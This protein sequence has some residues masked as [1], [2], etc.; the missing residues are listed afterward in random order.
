MQERSHGDRQQRLTIGDALSATR[1][2]HFRPYGV[3]SRGKMR[4]A[5]LGVALAMLAAFL[6]MVSPPLSAQAES[7]LPNGPMFQTQTFYAYA[8]DGETLDVDFSKF[9]NSGTG[10]DTTFA[11]TD[12]A[13]TVAY[14]CSVLA[15][16]P[17]GTECATTG[18]TG[19]AGVWTIQIAMTADENS[20]WSRFD[21]DITVRD[22]G[23]AQPGR[24]WTNKYIMLQ[25]GDLDLTYHL[26]NDSGYQYNV[27]LNGYN[28]I[29]SVIAANALGLTDAEC[30][31]LYQSGAG[32]S[33]CGP[34]YRIFF[35]EPDATLPATA[36]SAAGTLSVLPPVL[37]SDDL[38]VDD[39]TFAPGALNSANGTFTYSITDRF[40][41]GYELQID[42]DGNGSYSDAVDRVVE[43]G[44]DGSG[45]YSYDFD[46]LDGEGVAIADCT[47]IN[48]RIF[49]GKV[50]EVHVLQ[51]DV[52][53]RAGGIEI[54]RTNGSGAPDSTIYWDDTTLSDDRVTTTPQVDGTAGVDSTGG[55][56]GWDYAS[57]NGWG[58]A[59]NIDDWAYNPIN[60]GTG[61]ISIG[62][63]CL[64]IEK[65][66]NATAESRVGDTVT[67]TV[68]ATNT[69]DTDYTAEEP[70]VLTDDLTGVLDDATFNNDATSDRG[71]APS[72]TEPK[73]R[74]AGALPAGE[75]VTVSYTV[76]LTAGG[77][78]SVRNVA[79]DGDG[80]TPACDP[81][82]ADGTDPETGVACA[83][84]DNPLPKLTVTKTADRTDLPAVGEQVTYTVTVTNQGPG[85]YTADAPATA[86]DNFTDI[87]DDATF[88][89]GSVTASTG[90]TSYTDPIL[91]WE[92]A[93]GVGEMATVS[94]TFTYTGGGDNLLRNQ[95]C[96]PSDEAAQGAEPCA[97]VVVP[98]AA[99]EQSKSVDP[100][101]GTAVRAGQEVTYTLTFDNVGESAGA[102]D[103][104]DDLSDVLD[105]AE[106]SAGPTVTGDG[107]TATL[108]GEQIDI[109]GS[110]AAGDTVT[111]SYTV[112]VNAYADQANHQLGNVLADPDG[113][114]CVPG[115]EACATE[116]PIQHLIVEKTS[117]AQAD[118][119]TGDTVTYTVTVTNDGESDFTADAPASANDD[120]TAVLDDAQ[121]N[122]DATTDAGTV[123]YTEPTLSWSGPLAA[124]ESVSITYTVLVTNAGDHALRN[125]ASLPSELCD[126]ADAPC[127]AVV[128]T[129]LPHVVPTKISDPATGTDVVA[130]QVVTYTL[131]YTNDGQADGV[132]DSTDDLTDVLDDADITAEPVSSSANVTAVR[133]GATLRVTGSIAVGETVTVTYQITIKADGDRGNNRAENVLVPDVPEEFDC[134]SGECVPV[135][136]PPVVHLMPELDDWKTVD[137]AS[138]A[139]VAPGSTVTY[140]LNFANTGTATGVVNREDVLTGVID[141]ADLVSGPTS[142]D[143]ALT[144][145]DVTDGRFT[146]TGSLAAGQTVTVTYTVTVREDGQRGDDQLANFLVD[147]GQEPPA[148]CVV[149]DP[150]RPDCTVNYVSNVVAEKSSDP[151]SGSDVAQGE[152]ITYTLTFANTS[153]NPLAADS[154]VEYTDHMADVLD[155][156][157]LSSGPTASSDALS[158]TTEGTTIVITGALASGATATVSYTVTVKP[159]SEQGNHGLGNVV[160]ITGTDPICVSGS[161]LCTFHN[162]VKPSP[163]LASTGADVGAAGLFGL[164][165][166]F[167]GA[168]VYLI[169]RRRQAEA[170][171]ENIGTAGG[172]N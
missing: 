7:S 121:F 162:P 137:P 69:G 13:G 70:A 79:F 170:T 26:V 172:S 161:S 65:S 101:S 53:G 56:H 140:T 127:E 81:P 36:P 72:Y 9:G 138:G 149:T 75:S 47:L 132:V 23:T 51:N 49:F 120:L 128:E 157:T 10:L 27:N 171:A 77:D 11:I 154:A 3:L 39:L 15:A 109:A 169:A 63:R 164:L 144:A 115:P 141:D 151:E 57:P 20:N 35:D 37:S 153:S 139:T 147:P 112:I 148:E 104:F 14:N 134:T 71:D 111:V 160:A 18:L 131:G 45:S 43:L 61:E 122:D 94:Y 102:V 4:T 89:E 159:Y 12:A 108:N 54:I 32:N 142:S 129:L 76:D 17:A 90:E 21:W 5:A 58:D 74:W 64:S 91:S 42:T 80:D 59:R 50:G 155:D 29:G 145:S 106:L 85:V 118:V 46:G 167:A 28:G 88:D 87:L 66:S 146:V 117:D 86:S 105:D 55:V 123:S 116:N 107:L 16:A 82:T 41:G 119:N 100:E 96:I 114:A 73:I 30:T 158:V 67:Y 68:T 93:L 31:P 24:V 52:E 97:T 25:T 83:V 48:A 163:G 130:G 166:L 152:Q 19:P 33:N 38:I 44:A 124:G 133:D 84:V 136:P 8:G 60:F 6:I 99:V 125:V 168:G 126:T 103:T 62:G 95:A 1:H 40:Q 22:A 150:E 92:G 34:Q 165:T 78:G 143:A 135:T 98:A 2:Q 113:N 156:A 110:I